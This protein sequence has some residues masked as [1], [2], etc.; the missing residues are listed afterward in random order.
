MSLNYYK[1]LILAAWR[2]L[3]ANK[4][5]SLLTALGVI[6]GVAAVVTIVA[7][8]NGAQALILSEVQSFGSNLIGV[9][10]GKSETTGPPASVFG[11]TI[12]TL[13]TADAEAMAD[14]K[15]LPHVKSVAPFAQG[16]GT[17]NWQGVTYSTNLS[18]TGVDYIATEG[19]NLATGRWF[20]ADEDSALARVV[21]LGDTARTQLFGNS[22]PLG[23]QI[24]IG[25]AFFQVIGTMQKKG[26]S[27]TM[28][29]DDRV[30]L[31]VQTMQKII[32]G[33]NYLGLIH[34]Q[35]DDSKNINQT[36]TDLTN[37]LRARH[38][39]TDQSGNS[40]DFSV[41]SG[42]QAISILTTITDALKYFLAAMAAL[43]LLVGGIGIMNIMLIRVTERTREIG[44]R[45]A[46]GARYQDILSQFLTEAT[47]LTLSG[48]VI[49]IIVGI[50]M[51][52][53]VSVVATYLD[54]TWPLVISAW[55]IVIAVAVSTS[56]GLIFG[57]YP[58]RKA[59][60]LDPIEALRYE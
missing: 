12:T 16:A 21:I 5:R 43:S 39:I 44:L 23:Q 22:D 46:V 31:P 42:A 37:L 10:P 7:I 57:L 36:I 45:K 48:G 60:R 32:S 26:S 17:L 41:R 40:D 34:M 38:N 51:S 9:L 6:I 2:G 59:A 25:N 47:V 56:I 15:N 4:R 3:L 20:T 27:G 52:W 1:S 54:Y 50:G 35:V 55:S 33:T 28:D 24:K 30:F 19:G 18:G 58:A 49:G 13:T 53:L 8:G 14:K 29:V 11:V